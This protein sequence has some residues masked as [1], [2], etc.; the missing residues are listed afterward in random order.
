MKQQYLERQE[1]LLYRKGLYAERIMYTYR[2]ILFAQD[3]Y[4]LVCLK[5][6]SRFAHDFTVEDFFLH[7][8]Q[9]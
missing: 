5:T 1:H 2:N 7:A 4:F 8:T 9:P 6:I 3:I